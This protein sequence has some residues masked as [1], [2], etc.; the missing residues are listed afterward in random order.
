V[1]HQLLDS[2]LLFFA[3]LVGGGAVLL[4]G[5]KMV[6]RMHLLLTFSGAFIMGLIFLHLVPEVFSTGDSTIGWYVLCGFVLQVLLEYVSKGVEH[7]HVHIHD[8]STAHA[9][10]PLSVF[11]SLCLHALIE[12]MPLGG[13]DHAHHGDHESSLLMGLLIHKIPIAIA[14]MGLLIGSGL[15]KG[16]AFL[17]VA[18]FGLMGPLGILTYDL[19]EGLNLGSPEHLFQITNG[20]LIGILLHISTTILFESSD[21]HRFNL[22]K[23]LII[24][25]GIALSALTIMG[26]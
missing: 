25:I 4:F 6:T 8:H 21:G 1:T 20:L 17:M 10:F 15:K 2:S 26:H 3:A 24:I 9:A 18:I 7:G 14:L 5:D 22:L 19:I 12:S 11:I 13:H 23:L 16:K